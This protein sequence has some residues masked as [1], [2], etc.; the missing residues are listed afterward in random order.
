[1]ANSWTPGPWQR[2]GLHVSAF[3]ITRQ[4]TETHPVADVYGSANARLIAHAPEMA[5]TLGNALEALGGVLA[6]HLTPEEYH[7]HG[8]RAE[9]AASAWTEARAEIKN[10]RALLSRIRGETEGQ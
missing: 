9:D 2:G 7:K 6:W 3:V 10:I 8:L 5:E 4:G 1:M